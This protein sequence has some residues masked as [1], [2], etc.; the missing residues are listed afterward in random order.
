MLK[1]H[2]R[3]VCTVSFLLLALF[4]ASCAPTPTQSAKPSTPSTPS[5]TTPAITPTAPAPKTTTPSTVTPATKPTAPV[6]Q[7]TAPAAKPTA[8]ATNLPIVTSKAIYSLPKSGMMCLTFDDGFSNIQTIL[9]CLRANNV[10]CTFFIIGRC[11]KANPSL[12]RQAVKDGNEICY[13]TMTHGSITDLSNA[14]ILNDIQEWNNLAHEILGNDYVIPKLARL[15]GGGGNTNERV[16]AVFHNLGYEVIA[17]NAD[18]F[19]GV[20][21]GNN[22]SLSVINQQVANYVLNHA[23]VGTI[24]L[25]HFNQYDAPSIKLYITTLKQ[26][27][28]LG[29][30]SE[31]IAL[32][33]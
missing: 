7:P 14:Q 31:A 6:A 22:N 15:P 13:H 29:K 4:S 27:Y 26:K 10:H 19:T 12:W 17:W 20:I 3:L 30:I 25:Q 21:R 24:Q 28:K 16:L 33:K 32:S 18:S 8:P 23:Q 11:L 1:F 5:V 9:D 2:K